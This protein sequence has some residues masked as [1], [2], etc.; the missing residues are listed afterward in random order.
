MSIADLISGAVALADNAFADIQVDVQHAPKLS[1]DR[2]GKPTYDG[3]TTRKAIVAMKTRLL[4]TTDGKQINVQGPITFLRDETINAEDQLTL[5][6]GTV[7]V[8]RIIEKPLKP[9]GGG[10]VTKV[11]IG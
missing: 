5:P 8:I 6:D 9:S 7:G 11:W 3:P 10:Y 2:A 1:R 4:S